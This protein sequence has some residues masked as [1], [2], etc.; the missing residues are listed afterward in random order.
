MGE[1]RPGEERFVGAQPVCCHHIS[2]NQYYAFPISLLRCMAFFFTIIF[3]PKTDIQFQFDFFYRN[4]KQYIEFK[5]LVFYLLAHLACFL[6]SE[7]QCLSR[8]L[9]G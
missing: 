2:S 9:G 4:R 6:I 5:L 3:H 1:G 8:I 7:H